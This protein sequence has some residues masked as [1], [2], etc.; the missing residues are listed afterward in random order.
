MEITHPQPSLV[1]GTPASFVR[2]KDQ[3]QVQVSGDHVKTESHMLDAHVL[4]SLVWRSLLELQSNPFWKSDYDLTHWSHVF[5]DAA[6]DEL[7]KF[8]TERN[9]RP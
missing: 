2:T 7:G 4:Y 5:P 9:R 1:F 3:V 6:T 8:V